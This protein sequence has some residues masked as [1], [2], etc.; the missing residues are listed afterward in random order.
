MKK[1][2]TPKVEVIVFDP[3]DVIATSL[4]LQGDTDTIDLPTRP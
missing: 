3:K 4:W 1:M 2:E